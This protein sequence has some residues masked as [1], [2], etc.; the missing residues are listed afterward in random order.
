MVLAKAGWQNQNEAEVT[1]ARLRQYLN[2]SR[3]ANS[4]ASRCELQN[5]SPPLQAGR[6][7]FTCGASSLIDRCGSLRGKRSV[8][9]AHGSGARYPRVDLQTE[10]VAWVAKWWDT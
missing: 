8:E 7:Q 4:V 2:V 6:F 10:K 3:N 1:I 5:Y 9:V